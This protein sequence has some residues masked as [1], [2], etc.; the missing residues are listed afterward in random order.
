MIK[1]PNFELAKTYI[2][3]YGRK[4][5]QTRFLYYFENGTTDDVLEELGKFQNE[6]GGFGHGLESDLRSEN[7]SVIATC[8]ALSI[9]REIDIKKHPLIDNA[10]QYLLDCYDS[11]NKVFP[12]ITRKVLD[13]PHPWWWKDFENV[14]SGFKINPTVEALSHLKFFDSPIPDG[15]FD[16]SLTRIKSL[17]E[18]GI[19][20][21]RCI[22]H[23]LETEQFDEIIKVELIEKL[24]P[25]ITSGIAKEK[26]D[27]YGMYPLNI[28][29][30]PEDYFKKAVNE[31]LIQANLEYDSENQTEDGTWDLNWSWAEADKKLWD[32]A[33]KE[34]KGVIALE[35]L[36]VFKAFGR[37]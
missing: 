5:E 13:V 27:G 1:Q 19:Y 29:K 37:V 18:I 28:V 20:D 17:D 14:F 2:F 34:W 26:W 4:L 25:L 24:I 12:I 30:H 22:R 31:D 16:I 3:A 9:C 6:D 33:E 11:D 23:L 15:L 35:K 32:Q 36:L 7:S 8:H 10:I 21:I